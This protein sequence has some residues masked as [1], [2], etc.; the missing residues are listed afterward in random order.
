MLHKTLFV[1]LFVITIVG[2]VAAQDVSVPDLTGM[3]VPQAAATLQLPSAIA[4]LSLPEDA[5][6]PKA[7][8]LVD[9]R[10]ALARKP[11]VVTMVPAE[12]PELRLLG[13]PQ[14]DLVLDA[15]RGVGLSRQKASYLQDLCTRVESGAL[16]LDAR[17][18]ADRAGEHTTRAGG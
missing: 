18:A 9:R 1:L 13:L 3:A 4:M 15:L 11:D 17:P 16:A 8:V 5:D 7:C 14:V 6:L 10:S 2:V 12:A